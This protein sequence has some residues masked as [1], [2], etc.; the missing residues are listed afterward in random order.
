M[1]EELY[2]TAY[3]STRTINYLENHAADH[4]DS[5]FFI[6]CSFNDPH[7][8]FTPPGSY[9][10]K[11]DPDD[12]PVPASHGAHHNAP[13][14]LQKKLQAALDQSERIE[15]RVEAFACTEREAKEG[16]ALTYDMITM[17][18]ASDICIAEGSMG[19]FDGV[20]ALFKNINQHLKKQT[21]HQSYP[22]ACRQLELPYFQNFFHQL[23]PKHHV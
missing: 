9:L 20:I 12:M 19:L 13:P 6:Q 16:I 11:Y 23:F 10:G 4:K 21:S 18:D 22:F 3:I 7:H 1:P 14:P 17:V 2:S 5:P 15:I 8:P